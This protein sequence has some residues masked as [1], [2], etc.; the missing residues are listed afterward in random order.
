M[1]VWV[2]C[3]QLI[4]TLQKQVNKQ[5]GANAFLYCGTYIIHT[6]THICRPPGIP[7]T[8]KSQESAVIWE[9]WCIVLEGEKKSPFCLKPRAPG[10]YS[11]DLCYN[12]KQC[13]AIEQRW[14]NKLVVVM[15]FIPSAQNIMQV[16]GGQPWRCE[17]SVQPTHW[18]HHISEARPQKE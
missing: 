13:K 16:V 15:E 3:M 1:H 18:C 11:C 7:A 9:S 5:I 17:Y 10:G 2:W 14:E 8:F 12:H 4:Q 6:S